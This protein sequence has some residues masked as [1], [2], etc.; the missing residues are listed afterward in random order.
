MVGLVIGGVALLGAAVVGYLL[1]LHD[2]PPRT[3]VQRPAV[4]SVAPA[5]ARKEEASAD[6][7]PYSL[8]RQL[9]YYRTVQ[10]P[11][12]IVIAKSQHFL[13]V[14]KPNSAALRYTFG[15]GPDCMELAGLYPVRKEGTPPS[16]PEADTRALYLG[17]TKCRIRLID[18]KGAIAQ[19]VRAPG[20]QLV[21]DDFGD[22][23]NRTDLNTRVVVTN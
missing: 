15:M 19:N 6:N 23:F 1:F 21:E 11:D 5:P 16:P 8:R 12:T 22:L 18:P 7:V 3:T 17:D 13:Y 14:V 10:P 2:A 20:L 4:S 9:V